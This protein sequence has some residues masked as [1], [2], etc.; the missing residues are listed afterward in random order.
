MLTEP[1]MHVLLALARLGKRWLSGWALIHAIG[2]QLNSR[3]GG[4]YADWIRSS[5]ES[6]EADG[7]VISKGKSNDYRLRMFCLTDKG[8]ERLSLSVH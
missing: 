4:E 6:L 8:S 3:S 5:L 7:L 2:N 1:E